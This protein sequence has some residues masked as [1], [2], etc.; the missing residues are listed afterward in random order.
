MSNSGLPAADG[1]PRPEAGPSSGAAPIH[2]QTQ[3]NGNAS[4][5]ANPSAGGPAGNGEASATGGPD[6]AQMFAARRE[7]ELARRDRSLAEF[8]VMLDGYKPL[9]R[10]PRARWLHHA[11]VQIP[12]EVTEYYLQRSGF[13]CSD[14]RLYACVPVCCLGESLTVAE[15]GCF[16]YRRRSL[17]LT[18]RATHTI[19]PS[20]E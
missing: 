10:G 5:I 7:E 13:D 3:P 4:A 12:E 8:L 11:D 1:N 6:V 2:T 18:S 17:S 14:P 20:C 19:S 9:V 15:S 16:R